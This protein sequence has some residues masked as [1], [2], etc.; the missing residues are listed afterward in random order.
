MKLNNSQKAA[1]MRRAMEIFVNS[2]SGTMEESQMME[3]ASVFPEWKIGIAYKIKDVFKYGEN[4]V[5]DSQLYQV[6]QDH[7]SQSHGHQIQLQAY[8]KPLV[9]PQV[10]FL[11]GFSHW[12]LQMP[13]QRV[14]L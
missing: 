4:K 10:V 12:E 7:T 6:L 2:L 5:G 14:I 9:L 8:I 3:V 1:E 11:N 13:M